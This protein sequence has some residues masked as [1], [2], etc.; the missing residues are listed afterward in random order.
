MNENIN[1]GKCLIFQCCNH[2][3][4]LKLL[5][6]KE[7]LDPDEKIHHAMDFEHPPLEELEGYIVEVN[8]KI[9]G[10]ASELYDG[11]YVEPGEESLEVI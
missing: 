11:H 6:S 1:L 9:L 4:P 2:Y 7:E 10:K 8:L 5:R 3:F